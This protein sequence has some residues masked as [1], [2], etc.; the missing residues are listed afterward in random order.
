M[1]INKSKKI[2]IKI[3]SSILI[4]N[5]GKL[6]KD[7]LKKFAIDIKFL[8]KNNKEVIIVS[9]GAI[10][11]GRGQ[12]NLEDDLTLNES[13]AVAARGQIELMTAWKNEFKKHKLQVAQILLSPSDAENKKSSKNAIATIENLISFKCIPIINE[14]DV[15][16]TEELKFGDN[17]RLSAIVSIILKADKLVLITDKEGLYDSDPEISEEAQKIENIEYNSEE[18]N[19]L[20]PKSVSGKGIGGFSTKIMAAQMAGFSGIETQIISWSPNCVDDVIDDVKIGTIIKP[21]N[22]NIKLKKIWIGFGMTIDGEII[23]DEGAEDALVKDASLLSKGVLKVNQTFEENTGVE[24]KNTKNTLIGRGVVNLSSKEIED[25]KNS[26][27]TVVI[28]K[29]NLLIL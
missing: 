12:L 11:L 3:G 22:K 18:L 25:S 19:E 15:V 8:K 10:A 5:K 2:V 28:H 9:S 29:D 1:Y 6:K 26:E 27:N 7:W 20:I 16:A 21:S 23:I 13:Q 14:N 24:I 4:D 17:D